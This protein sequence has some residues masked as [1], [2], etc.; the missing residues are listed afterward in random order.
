MA[1]A[2]GLRRNVFFPKDL[3]S[4]VENTAEKSTDS[5]SLALPLCQPLTTQAFVRE[6]RRGRA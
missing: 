6:R 1:I 2:Q 5:A 3:F 4:G